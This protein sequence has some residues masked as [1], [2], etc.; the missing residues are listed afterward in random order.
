VNNYG[1]ISDDGLAR[2]L[3]VPV[4]CPQT[5]LRKGSSIVLTS[6]TLNEGEFFRV[7]FI[8]LYVP[9]LVATHG[10]Y[11]KKTDRYGPVFLGLYSGQINNA[12]APLGAPIF[13]V[14]ADGVGVFASSPYVLRNFSSADLYTFMVVNNTTNYD[15]DAVVTGTL[16]LFLS[17]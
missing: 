5:E 15:Y 3:S 6:F 7:R 2:I 10:A 14:S 13:A 4:A 8:S 1:Y 11:A 12:N 17:A 16:R 9:R